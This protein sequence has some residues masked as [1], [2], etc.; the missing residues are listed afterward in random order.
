[1]TVAQ[2]PTG[3][4][5]SVGVL[6]PGMS[7][8][9]DRLRYVDALRGFAALA[10]V[11]HHM[12]HN[13]VMEPAIRSVTPAWLEVALTRGALGVQ[14]FFVLSGFVLTR[15]LRGRILT[16]REGALF[17]ARRQLRLDPVYW[18]AIVVALMTGLAERLIPEASTATPSPS[19]RDLLLNVAYLHEIFDTRA[20]LSVSWTLCIEVQF[21]LALLLICAA[22]RAFGY[23]DPRPDVERTQ[24]LAPALLVTGI[25]SVI[26]AHA[27][28]TD[29]WFTQYWYIFALGALLS[30]GL[31]EG[32]SWVSAGILG[33]VVSLAPVVSGELTESTVAVSVAVAVLFSG[34]LRMRGLTWVANSRVAGYLGARSYSLYLVH[35]TILSAVLRLG[36]KLTDENRGA[37]V[38]WVAMAFAACFL[39]TEVLYRVVEVPT[40]R[41]A[42][43]LKRYGPKSL[44]ATIFSRVGRRWSR[45][46]EA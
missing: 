2:P 40:L 13:T 24:Y 17:I 25:F 15:S 46:V 8:G 11:G 20:V 7:V 9:A 33:T 42:N 26:A 18:A 21:Y 41:A 37:A 3:V 10:V 23:G 30:L 19:P 28:V 4:L 35:L 29:A 32:N 45:P 22:P 14:V 16:R 12:Q 1:V 43:H 27:S 34:H 5:N 6:S 44:R 31:E 38:G 39:A 36:Y